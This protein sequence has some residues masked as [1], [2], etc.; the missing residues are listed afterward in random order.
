MANSR[1]LRSL[2][3]FDEVETA[4][5]RALES[6]Q[7]RVSVFAAENSFAV[8]YSG[9]LDSSVLLHLASRHAKT[10]GTALHAFHVHH[11]LSPNADAWLNH[12]E[13]ESARQGAQ[14]KAVRISIGQRDIARHGVEQAARLARYPALGDL[15]RSHGIRL[16][17][18]AHHQD[19]QAETL[20]LQLMRGAGL[21]GL[22]GMAAF[23][24]EHALLGK[25]R[26]L[27]RPLL[28]VGRAALEE[29]AERYSLHYV[30]DESNQDASYRRNALRHTVFPLLEEHFPG[31]SSCVARSA[32]H[33]QSVQQ[34]VDEL[35][36]SDLASC[37]DT[38]NEMALSL[39]G[40]TKL[41]PQRRDNVLRHWLKGRGMRMP[42]AARLDQVQRQLLGSEP[43]KHPLFEFEEFAL[44]RVGQLLLLRPNLGS[45]QTEELVLQWHGEHEI[46]VPS[47]HGA[48]VFEHVEGSGIAMRELLETPLAIKPRMGQ[49]R[50]KISPGRPSKTLKNLFQEAAIPVWQ[51]E[52]L[53]L[54]YLQENLIAVAGLGMD[55]RHCS[56]GDGIRLTWRPDWQNAL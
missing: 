17:L 41:S 23:Q 39:K 13:T 4:F 24:D 53:P 56:S 54:I 42:S 2:I 27:G 26:C 29:Y 8:A 19:D 38:D 32:F 15:C 45:P 33:I 7:A 25:D 31:F 6:F 1:K 46:A 49:E 9:G 16:L 37:R 48:L 14:F 21:A 51:R 18:A 55:V 30:V 28:E 12:C 50:L 10:R 40:I 44:S 22:S 47:W 11:G 36:A 3:K 20:M 34:L 43:G 5:E 52:W 35:A